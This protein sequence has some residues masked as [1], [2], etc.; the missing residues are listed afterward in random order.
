MDDQLKTGKLKSASKGKNVTTII[1]LR[2]D[3]VTIIVVIAKAIQ[4]IL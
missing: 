3:V 2:N 4:Q 1:I